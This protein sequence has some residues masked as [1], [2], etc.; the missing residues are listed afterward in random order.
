MLAVAAL[1]AGPA[2]A[3]SFPVKPLRIVTSAP[4]GTSDF[5]S[6]IIARGLTESLGQQVIVDNRGNFGAEVVV[7]AQ[8]DGYTLLVE[9]SSVWISPMLQHAPYDPL[10]DFAPVTI[11]V[12]AANVLVVN[13]SVRVNSV[14]ELIAYA[15]AHPGE[16]NYATGGIGGASH[17]PAEL[18]K[19]LAGVNIVNVNYKGTGPA[20]N[21]VLAGEAQIMFSNA[22]ITLGHLKAGRLKALAVT[23]LEPSPVLPGVP[24]LA[25][26][27]FPG[28][29]S[30]VPLGVIAPARTPP[31]LVKRLNQEIV[32]VLN[33]PDVKERHF[34][35]GVETVGSTPEEF[36]A[37]I[38]S[39]IARWGKV[40]REAG[41]RIE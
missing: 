2:R 10:K 28:F 5:T 20:L 26:S 29:E 18:F 8:P 11:A 37:L 12:K 38:R 27:G 1:S 13:A 6:R 16:L 14:K 41:I 23:S 21:A 40:I 15:K 19:S 30:I 34:S 22:T 31:A 32:R 17:L 25:S 36:T 33:R 4:G 39:D 9:G 3:Q 7:R 35:I 24:T